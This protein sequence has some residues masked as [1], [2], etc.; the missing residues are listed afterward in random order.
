M[1]L[2]EIPLALLLTISIIYNDSVKGLLRLWPLIIALCGLMI[3]IFLYFF[4][5]ISISYEEIRAIGVFS[6]KDSVSIEKDK[7]V[8]LTQRSKSRLKVELFG[9]DEKPGFDWIKDEEPREINLF[10]EKAVGGKG[11]IIR[12]LLFFGVTAED[13]E[14]IFEN[15]VFEK[16]YELVKVSSEI[17]NNERKVNIRLLQTV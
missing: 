3:F 12:V 16:E 4:R 13:A 17:V 11:S 15:E 6:S 2:S 9:V 8:V 14:A 7:T 1:F 5:M 10:N